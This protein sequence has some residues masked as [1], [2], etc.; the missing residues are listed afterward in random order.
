M[1]AQMLKKRYG[2]GIQFRGDVLIVKNQDEVKIIGKK[3]LLLKN[4]R[5]EEIFLLTVL[6]E[7]LKFSSLE[8]LIPDKRIMKILALLSENDF[9]KT[10]VSKEELNSKNGRQLDWL[11]HFTDKP[12]EVSINLENKT[13]AILGCG[14]TGSIVATHLARAGL[15]KFLLLDG[16]V[17]DLPDL[18]R[19]FTYFESDCGKPK[20]EVLSKYLVKTDE[21]ISVIP[22]HMKIETEG[23]VLKVLNETELDLVINCAD[24]PVGLIHAIVAKACAIKEIPVLFGG[25]GLNDATVGPL[26]TAPSAMLSYADEMVR[27]HKLLKEHENI[28]KASI[29]FTNTLT[30]TQLAFEAFKFLTGVISPI[31][32]NQSKTVNFVDYSLMDG[33]QWTD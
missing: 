1:T 20:V 5:A 22:M 3:T 19:Q 32:A 11:S 25:V 8:N 14:G 2:S 16:S 24:T 4:L 27:F 31:V 33:K 15:K 30:A 29:C 28:L 23:D 18:N 6:R 12:Q 10:N 9:F 17:V 13:V 21:T 7:G 26:F